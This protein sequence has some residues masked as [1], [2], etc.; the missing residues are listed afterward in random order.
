MLSP[1]QW[2]L[3]ALVPPAILALYFLKLRRRP[4]VVSSTYLWRRSL[5][6]LHVNSLWQ[7]LRQSLLLFL[8]L[9]A[10][11]LAMLALARPAW[12][13]TRLAGDRFIFLIDHSASMTATDVAPNR[14]EEARR[15]ALSLLDEMPSGAVAMVIS[16]SDQARVE[17]AFTDNRR[18]LRRAL[19][20]IAPTQRGTSLREALQV[21]AGLANP[22]RVATESQ[23]LQVADALPATL[24]ILS[25]GKFP[26]VSG[27]SLGNLEPR[28]IPIGR[29]DTP[30]LGIVA[31]H[32]RRNPLAEGAGEAFA[33]VQNFGREAAT[34][35]LSL[36]MDGELIDAQ[37]LEIPAGEG[38]SAVFALGSRERGILTLRIS[39]D[40]SLPLDNQAWSVLDP[41]ERTR[42]LVIGPP[43]EPLRLALSTGS[44]AQT[45]EVTFESPAFVA[46][47]EYAQQSEARKFDLVIFDRVTPPT[48]PEAP[49]VYFG[50]LPPG[51]SWKA[52]AEISP[53]IIDANLAHPLL[54]LLELWNV[55]IATGFTLEPPEGGDTLL[56]SQAG[57]I[58]AVAPRGGYEDLVIGFSLVDG[59]RI[60]TN[61]PLRLS[62]PLFTMNLL[63]Y[64]GR[65][66][67]SEIPSYRPGQLVELSSETAD[68]RLTVTAPGGQATTVGRNSGGKFAFAGTQTVGVYRVD[69]VGQDQR[70]FSVN[71][72]SPAESDLPV[73]PENSIRIGY[74]EVKGRA[75]RESAPRE[76][77]KWL[78]LGV[79]AVL[80]VEWYIYNRRVYL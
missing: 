48:S 43:N 10:V 71:L 25:D 16:F 13:G 62:F 69:A 29:A 57:P 31:F 7:R 42:V 61:W 20:Q 9:L 32:A 37:Q 15:R 75:G 41:P 53:Q 72:F 55:D 2:A 65:G 54:N 27:F 73:R 12:R 78:A 36:E 79:L 30:N 33:R 45:A 47:P 68:D 56:E 3:L 67:E 19:A 23:D 28:Y 21:A 38:G 58:M 39:S 8:Q 44:I 76:L 46:S 5:E 59:E 34:V 1:G 51:E 66:G 70:R 80:M 11:L 52:G 17:Q 14:L 18:A 74:V 24:L 60:N 4:V 63:R 77:W 50:A 22:G 35:E 26:D 40:D 6:D 49:A 64:F